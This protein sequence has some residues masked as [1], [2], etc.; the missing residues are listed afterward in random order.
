MVRRIGSGTVRFRLWDGS[1]VGE[2]TAPAVVHVHDRGALWQ[3]CLDPELRFGELYMEGRLGVEGD[4]PRLLAA[5]YRGPEGGGARRALRWLRDGSRRRGLQQS[6]DNIHRHYDLGNDFYRLWLDRSMTYTCAYFP[7]ADLTLE[8]AQD[9]KA[10]LVC[11]KLCLQPGQRV[12]EAGGGWGGLALYMARQHG[13]EVVSY[14]ISHEQVRWARERAAAEGLAD[15]ID[16]VEDDYRHIR[17][18]FDVFV[19]VGML[20]HVGKKGYAELGQIVDR[21][22]APDGLAL[23][24]TIGRARPMPLNAWIQK[25]IFPGAYPPTLR[26]MMDLFEPHD[27]TVL[28]VENLRLHYA[29]TLEHWLARFESASDE[30]RARLGERFERA[31]RLY[32]SGSMAA[33]RAGKLELF[34]VL[35]TRSHNDRIPLSRKHLFAHAAGGRDEP[36]PSDACGG[37]R[38]RSMPR[39]S[40]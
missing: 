19:S 16:F 18:D 12:V 24:H 30:V 9:A 31:W 23:I 6:R 15:R 39:D 22:L 11:R 20:E 35:V 26:E 10:E 33:F 28:D 34:Q 29:R 4:L 21:C 27:F 38:P 32:L 17:G 25:R 8:Q 14:N 40:L 3:L 5:A 36:S 2:R 7:T 13:V 1:L 37:A